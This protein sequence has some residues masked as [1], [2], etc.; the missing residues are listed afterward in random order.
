MTRYVRSNF[1]IVPDRSPPPAGCTSWALLCAA[2][3]RLQLRSVSSSLGRVRLQADPA[4]Y[5]TFHSAS[6]AA[7]PDAFQHSPRADG[8]R[9]RRSMPNPTEDSNNG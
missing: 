7:W 8:W 6:A 4:V 9:P 1:A 2:V 5:L 3:G